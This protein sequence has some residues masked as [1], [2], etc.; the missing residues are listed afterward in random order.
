R[1]ILMTHDRLQKDELILTHEFLAM[2]LGVRRPGVTTA[3]HVLEGAGMIQALFSC[4]CTRERR[5]FRSMII[6]ILFT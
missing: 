1:W 5:Y 6:C 4:K 2:M 3:T